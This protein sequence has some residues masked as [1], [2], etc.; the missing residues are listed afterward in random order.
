ML[1]PTMTEWSRPFGIMRRRSVE[2]KSS[3]VECCFLGPPTEPLQGLVEL[4]ST[5]MSYSK[6][7]HSSQTL[8]PFEFV[9][10]C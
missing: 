2:N 9:S 6:G 10:V 4:S 1:P 8:E 5:R 3:M 7:P